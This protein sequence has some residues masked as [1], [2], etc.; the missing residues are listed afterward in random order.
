MRGTTGRPVA[1]STLLKKGVIHM[2]DEEIY[3]ILR[4]IRS[5]I[6]FSVTVNQSTVIIR[7]KK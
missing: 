7:I 5:G 1:V 4:L 3:F 2:S 6:I